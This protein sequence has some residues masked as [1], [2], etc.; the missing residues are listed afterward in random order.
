M[1]Q[2]C[3]NPML[4]E[5]YQGGLRKWF[6]QRWVNIAKKKKGG[7]H[8]ECGTSGSKRGYAKC[9]PAAKASSMSDKE[10]RSAVTRKRAAQTQAGRGGKDTGTAGKAP[11]R[12]ATKPKK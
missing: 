8:P 6:K 7:G 11:I 2:H 4:P 1:C 10:K 12:V 9:V 3:G 5:K